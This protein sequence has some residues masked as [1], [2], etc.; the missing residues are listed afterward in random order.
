VCGRVSV[1]RCWCRCLCVSLCQ[2]IV[3]VSKVEMAYY[4][5]DT[6]CANSFT[7]LLKVLNETVE[8]LQ[9]GCGAATS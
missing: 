4:E 3:L 6:E 7:T 2:C 1:C 8:P 9:L 5:A